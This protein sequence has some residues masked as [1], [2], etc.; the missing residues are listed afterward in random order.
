[1]ITHGCLANQYQSFT[2]DPSTLQIIDN[3]DGQCLQV[4]QNGAAPSGDGAPVV[5]GPCAPNDDQQRWYVEGY[6]K[7]SGSG[8]I[9]NYWDGKC[10]DVTGGPVEASLADGTAVVTST[11][12]GSYSQ[13]WDTS[14]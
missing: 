10:I 5:K 7:R 11:C 3:L 6:V 1:M 2:Y 13:A 14:Q 4:V 8:Q 12:N 9:V